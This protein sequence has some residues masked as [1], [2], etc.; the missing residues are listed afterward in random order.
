[1]ITPDGKQIDPN[2]T[3]ICSECGKEMPLKRAIK[4][5]RTSFYL[6]PK[7]ALKPREGEGN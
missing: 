5:E 7:C 4:R 2:P 1:M 3:A 6:C